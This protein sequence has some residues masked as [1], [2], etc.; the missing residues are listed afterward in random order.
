[1]SYRYKDLEKDFKSLNGRNETLE[2]E[3]KVIY[4]SI[5]VENKITIKNKVI[6]GGKQ[7]Q[8]HQQRR[9]WETNRTIKDKDKGFIEIY[10]LEQIFKVGFS[11]V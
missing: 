1:M 9:I 6:V 5:T 4:K 8:Q 10:I 11:F 2:R 7:Q 3:L